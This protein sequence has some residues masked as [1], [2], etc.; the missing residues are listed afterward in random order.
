MLKATNGS[1]S[2]MQHIPLFKELLSL[3]DL[4]MCSVLH[5][6]YCLSPTPDPLPTQLLG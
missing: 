5:C 4:K 1:V 6:N 2:L 3:R